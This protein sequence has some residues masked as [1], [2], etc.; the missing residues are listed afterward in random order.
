MGCVSGCM[1]PSSS[2]KMFI[3]ACQFVSS[4][5]EQSRRSWEQLL[6]FRMIEARSFV[7]ARTIRLPAESNT[8][9]S[10][11]SMVRSTGRGRDGR[12]L[13]LPRILVGLAG[14]RRQS[15]SP[16]DVCRDWKSCGYDV[17]KGEVGARCPHHFAPCRAGD[18]CEIGGSNGMRPVNKW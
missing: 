2:V 8:L 6:S 13:T 10:G 17:T 4:I 14:W 16:D 18:G 15:V 7:S 1:I 11:K 9:L 12:I 3:H 5:S